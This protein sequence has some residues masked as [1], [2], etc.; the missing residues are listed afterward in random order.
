[1]ATWFFNLLYSPDDRA[2]F[3]RSFWTWFTSY[4]EKKAIEGPSVQFR[5]HCGQVLPCS[6]R[7]GRSCSGGILQMLP[8]GSQLGFLAANRTAAGAQGC[9]VPRRGDLSFGLSREQEPGCGLCVPPHSC[10]G[11]VAGWLRWGCADPECWLCFPTP[12]V[13][14]EVRRECCWSGSRHYL[15]LCMGI[16]GRKRRKWYSKHCLIQWLLS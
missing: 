5:S 9:T 4:F 10:L 7:F 8:G 2:V 15:K 6:H 1:M 12:F 3:L 16:E 14:T 13:S 11:W